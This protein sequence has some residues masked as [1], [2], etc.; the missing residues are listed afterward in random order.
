MARRPGLSDAERGVLKALWDHGPGTIREINEV[1]A[2]RGRRWAY[3]TVA[4][5]MQRLGAKRYVATD[6]SSVPH[7]Y[8][9]IVTRD[10]LLEGLLKDAAKELCDGRAAPL[11]LALVQGHRFS[12]EELARFRRLLDAAT[13]ASSSAKAK[14]A[15]YIKE[16]PK[17]L[18]HDPES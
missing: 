6:P 15:R 10:Q 3:T 13:D 2:R 18:D 17:K 1:L 7:V 14:A 11:V 8:R 12:A 5:L 9:A 16:S 4:T